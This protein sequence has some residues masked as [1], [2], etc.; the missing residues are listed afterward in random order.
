MKNELKACPF[1]GSKAQLDSRDNGNNEN[2]YSV[3]CSNLMCRCG[4]CNTE[5]SYKNEEVAIIAWNKRKDSDNKQ[6]GF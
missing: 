2:W 1:C 6:E 4:A 3:V 5:Y